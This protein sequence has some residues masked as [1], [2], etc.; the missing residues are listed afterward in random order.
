MKK[1]LF[2]AGQYAKWVI[3]FLGNENINFIVDNDKNKSGTN[4]DGIP[5]FYYGDV[6]ERLVNYQIVISV[7]DTYE[8][9][10]IGQLD[11]DGIHNYVSFKEVKTRITRERILSQ[12]NGIDAYNKAVKWIK[13]NTLS[14]GCI[15]CN[16]NK[17]KGY[18]EVTGY[19]IPTLI[20]WGYRDLAIKYANWLISIQQ[21]D[22]SWLD[23]D[24]IDSYI[25]DTGQ[26]LKGLIAVRKVYDGDLNILDEAI[27]RACDWILSRMTSE[28]RLDTPSKR[29]WGDGSVCSELVHLYCLSTLRESAELFNKQHYLDSANKICKYY[30][31]NHYNEIV[32]FGILSHFYAYIMEALLDL[33]YVDICSEA[34]SKM[35]EIQRESGAIPAYHNVDWVCSTGMF[36]LAL[37]WYRLGKME[38]GN[39]A[40]EYACKLQNDTGGWYG[41]YLSESNPS[42][43]N[44]YFPFSEISWAN[45]YF[46][47]ALYY[48]T[49]AEFELSSEVFLDEISCKDGRFFY[50]QELLYSASA[51]RS[52]KVLDLGCGKG[53]YV[54]KLAEMFPHNKYCAVDISANVMDKIDS[55]VIEK[56]VGLL[57]C[58]PYGD[59]YFD[60]VYSCEALEHAVDVG[61]A[62]REMARVTRPGGHILVVDKNIKL[63]GKFYISSWEQWFDVEELKTIME[64]YCDRVMIQDKVKYD[65]GDD[66]LFCIWDGVVR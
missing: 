53:R 6:K 45:K 29:C 20:R 22:G 59:N 47:D 43:D 1:I 48:K 31:S 35:A 19:Y 50:I 25:F 58:I 12:F 56:K 38:E 37:V 4:V 40:F 17:R 66:D 10:V 9:A 62:I 64:R 39:K 57:T 23:T 14:E 52:I 13:N 26:V 65:G 7:S 36:Q 54:K 15:I 55:G 5:V 11:G 42:E 61:S 18:P 16:T 46:L 34:M 30:L 3:N 60:L 2:G 44:T 21:E 8:N 33:G 28:G 27:V 51:N 32:N 24:G 63:L 41:S 49:K